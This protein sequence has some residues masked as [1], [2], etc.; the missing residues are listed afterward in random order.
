MARFATQKAIAALKLE[1]TSGTEETL[2]DADF[3]VRARGIECTPELSVDDESSKFS[4][5]DYLGDEPIAG[6]EGATVKM[7][8]KVTESS[9]PATVDPLWWKLAEAC[10]CETKNY[11]TTGVAIQ[12]PQTADANSATIYYTDIAT[13]TAPVGVRQKLKGAMG[14]MVIS[15]EG[16]GM[17]VMANFEF[18]GAYSGSE[19]VSNANILELTSPDT[20]VATTL[21]GAT[22]L[23]GSYTPCLS[24]FTFDLGNSVEFVE[25][26]SQS[27]GI[28]QAEMASRNP[29]L[30]ATILL[31][32]IANYSALAKFQAET[33]ELF[34]VA[35]GNFTLKIA[36]AQVTGFS[37]VDV[38]G[39]A[40]LELTF[41]VLRNG[42]SDSDIGTG[43]SF[44]LLQGARA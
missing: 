3:N 43:S 9:T 1:S 40:G 14:N 34:S 27:T 31:D 44:E 18:K 26:P 42:T 11:T 8:V 19:D 37:K 5:G 35:W 15:S 7:D 10:G 4:T 12:D 33:V 22:L 21:K 25:C 24:A 30:T 16:V 41:A 32:T 23:I 13:G 17:P 29:T 36:K 2:A 38:N 39:K 20:T 28:I 6:I